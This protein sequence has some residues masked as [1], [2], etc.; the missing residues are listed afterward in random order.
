MKPQLNARK[1]KTIRA[2]RYWSR[3]I[4]VIENSDF[5]FHWLY[6]LISEKQI[7]LNRPVRIQKTRNETPS[8]MLFSIDSYSKSP[9]LSIISLNS[10]A[11]QSNSFIYTKRSLDESWFIPVSCTI[12]FRT[13]IR[14]E[15]NHLFL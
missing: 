4:F 11:T 1:G 15:S 5:P 10:S 6:F 8:C 3:V 9:M 2:T 13:G 7:K 14:S 12:P